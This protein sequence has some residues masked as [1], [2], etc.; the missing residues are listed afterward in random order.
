[1]RG[2]RRGV[3]SSRAPLVLRKVPPPGARKTPRTFLS[4]TGVFRAP[5]RRIDIS[6]PRRVRRVRLTTGRPLQTSPF[7]AR[8]PGPRAVVGRARDSSRGGLA[9]TARARYARRWARSRAL[10]R[11][12]DCAP[13][14]ADGRRP[15]RALGLPSPGRAGAAGRERQP[16]HRVR[17]RRAGRLPSAGRA[18]VRRGA[19]VRGVAPGCTQGPPR[20]WGGGRRAGRWGGGGAA[21][22]DP[23]ARGGSGWGGVAPG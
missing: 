6:S 20:G 22:S 2:R 13:A 14:T 18:G 10:R 12:D 1:M 3:Q 4:P 5:E 7:R 19:R 8:A 16:A 15:R 9:A 21:G 11:A 23:G 17:P